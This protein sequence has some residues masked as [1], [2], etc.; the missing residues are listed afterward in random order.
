V[1]LQG[2]LLQ[3]RV[4]SHVTRASATGHMSP[5]AARRTATTRPWR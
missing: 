1:S 4:V 2:Q 3:Q 5:D